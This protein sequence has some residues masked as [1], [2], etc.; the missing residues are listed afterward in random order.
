MLRVRVRPP[1]PNA[2]R[3]GC[4]RR[5]PLGNKGSIAESRS[6]MSKR[7]DMS[8]NCACTTLAAMASSTPSLLGYLSILNHGS[9][10]C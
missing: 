9:R 3:S 6:L 4:P 7:W 10:E 2:A 1:I 5:L 8:A